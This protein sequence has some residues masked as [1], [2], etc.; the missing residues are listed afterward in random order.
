VVELPDEDV[1]IF[2]LFARWIYFYKFHRPDERDDESQSCDSLSLWDA[3]RLWVFGD[4]RKI[5]DL[6]NAA[7][8]AWYHV[9]KIREPSLPVSFVGLLYA[10]TVDG[11]P[12]RKL[13]I[14]SFAVL[15]TFDSCFG[16]KSR[17]GRY[18]EDFLCE[19]LLRISKGGLCTGTLIERAAIWKNLDLSQFYV[20]AEVMLENKSLLHGQDS[21][22]TKKEPVG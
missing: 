2:E 4:K 7:I 6:M 13:V 22:D 9:R 19:L 16:E 3:S 12:L 10:N 20:P 15:A 5:P 1:K 18:P 14:E 17:P 11:S 8:D 21:G